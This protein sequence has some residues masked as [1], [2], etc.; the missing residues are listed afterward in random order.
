MIQVSTFLAELRKAGE[1]DDV[2]IKCQDLIRQWDGLDSYMQAF[3]Q[4]KVLNQLLQD[5]R[6]WVAQH[7]PRSNPYR[8]A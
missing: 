2:R 4:R 8:H 6:D 5:A 7:R 1:D 3:Y